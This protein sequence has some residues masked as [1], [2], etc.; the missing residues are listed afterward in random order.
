M[1]D[2]RE[3]RRAA[4]PLEMDERLDE[5][6]RLTD[7]E[8]WSEAFTLL[9]G[10]EDEYPD[11]PM[12]MALL[13]TVSSEMEARGMA[14]EY[15]RRGLAAGPTDPV[16][17]VLL[18]TGLARF[19]DPEAEGVLRLAA[20]TAP[21]V[22]AARLQYGA[23]LAREGM[24]ELAL[25]ELT[26]ARELDPD[27]AVVLRELGL[28]HWLSGDTEVSAENFERAAEVDPE[29]AEPVLIA[30]MMRLLGEEFADGAEVVVRS[31]SEGVEEGEVQIVAALAAAAE[32][33][34]DEAWNALARA[35]VAAIA[36]E[37]ELVQE[38][39]EAI[40]AGEEAA[41]RLLVE[42]VL[43]RLLRDRLLARS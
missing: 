13:G 19:D 8:N 30:G 27:D 32:G 28:V 23:Y 39:E 35:E 37:P 22:A 40:E 36:A 31:A 16:I 9:Q 21:H 38:A 6:A 41:R 2:S 33:W 10:M 26:A 7:E 29:D 11:D 18:G 25:Q 34:S 14:Y 1:E 43:P 42:E 20:I 17:L 3:E 12:L 24:H 4:Q 5:A 15:F